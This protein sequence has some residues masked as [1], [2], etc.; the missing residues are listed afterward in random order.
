[1]FDV[2]V[3]GG[4]PARVAAPLEVVGDVKRLRLHNDIGNRIAYVQEVAPTGS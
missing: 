2:V 1:M 3:I 4:G